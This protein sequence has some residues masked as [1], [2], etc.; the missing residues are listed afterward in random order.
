MESPSAMKI[1]GIMCVGKKCS[2]IQKPGISTNTSACRLSMIIFFFE[3]PHAMNIWIFWTLEEEC[4]RT[5]MALSGKI[6]EHLH[7][8]VS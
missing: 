7:E 5:W 1:M 4:R 8:T 3:I 2:G 6:I